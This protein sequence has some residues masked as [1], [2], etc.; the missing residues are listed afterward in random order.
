MA[1]N[2]FDVDTSYARST[3]NLVVQNLLQTGDG[4]VNGTPAGAL[5]IGASLLSTTN[6][7]TFSGSAI[8]FGLLYVTTDSAYWSGTNITQLNFAGS[9]AV[10][11]QLLGVRSVTGPLN[12]LNNAWG[13]G[14]GDSITNVLTGPGNVT[15]KVGVMLQFAADPVHYSVSGYGQWNVVGSRNVTASL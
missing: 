10:D 12:I 8:T 1:Q 9:R 5:G 14:A 4:Y 2:P 7:Y 15:G 11:G 3:T 6:T 13:V